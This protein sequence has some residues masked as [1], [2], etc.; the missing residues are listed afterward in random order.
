MVQAVRP[1]RAGEAQIDLSGYRL[2]HKGMLNGARELVELSL[3]LRAGADTLTKPRADALAV[4][5][6]LMT[7]EIHRHH[8]LEDDDIWPVIAA[9]AGPAVDLAPLTSDHDELDPIMERM[10]DATAAL[11]ERPGSR[12]AIEML[13]VE[14]VRLRDLLEEHIGEEERDVFPVMLE[15]VS[16]EDFDRLEKTAAKQFPLRDI[17]FLLP[18]FFSSISKEQAA[19]MAKSAPL[20]MKIMYVLFRGR[21]ARFHR[22]IFG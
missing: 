9:S 21:Y 20:P 12:P 14:A 8:S 5:V 6:R 15:H 13:A 1:R 3:R 10:R 4:Y 17:W 11:C 2:A 19:E 7:E 22:R 18:W 16:V